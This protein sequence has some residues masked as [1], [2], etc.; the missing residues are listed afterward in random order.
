MHEY[1]YLAFIATLRKVSSRNESTLTAL[2]TWLTLGEARR[3]RKSG[4][5]VSFF[6]RRK[7]KRV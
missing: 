2:H 6:C 5:M 7:G 4:S 3:S 1:T